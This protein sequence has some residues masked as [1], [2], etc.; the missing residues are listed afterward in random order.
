MTLRLLRRST[1]ACCLAA[2]VIV[3]L[4]SSRV[5]LAAYICPMSAAAG[6]AEM[7]AGDDSPALCHAHCQDSSFAKAG[8]CV[9]EAAAPF[10]SNGLVVSVAPSADAGA[11]RWHT[12]QVVR[13]PPPPRTRFCRLQI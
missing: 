3:A 11:A 4:A 5:A 2:L 8:D 10:V 6:L 1:L 12:P 7:D 13:P 9:A